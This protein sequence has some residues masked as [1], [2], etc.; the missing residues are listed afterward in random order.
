MYEIAA[1]KALLAKSGVAKNVRDFAQMM[2][3]AHTD[4]TNQLKTI[5]ASEK[6]SLPSGVDATHQAEIDQ[7]NAADAAQ[8]STL[9]LQQQTDAHQQAL[10]LLQN[11]SSSGDD[12]ALKQFAQNIQPTVQSHLDSAKALQSGLDAADQHVTPPVPSPFGRGSG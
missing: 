12:A 1:S 7:I 5:A 3:T 4:S 8:A 2:I 9:Y 11:Y 6:L 10:Q